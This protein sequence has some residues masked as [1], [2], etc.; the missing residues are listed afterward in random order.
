MMYSVGKYMLMAMYALTLCI[1]M[2]YYLGLLQ[3]AGW[4]R[5][6]YLQIL[7][8]ENLRWLPLLFML[9]PAAAL[10]MGYRTLVR[11]KERGRAKREQEKIIRI[12][13]FVGSAVG[14]FVSRVFR[15]SEIADPGD[16][17]CLRHSV[18]PAAVCGAVSCSYWN[19]GRAP[20][21]DKIY[22]E[23]RRS[24]EAPEGASD[25]LGFRER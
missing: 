8:R 25:H 16:A 7:L 3:E 17:S 4:S 9:I 23:I 5:K 2:R 6:T 21:R 12:V 24:F 15:Y 20:D 18:S 19:A 22:P 14:D 10:F 1:T 11:T 13:S